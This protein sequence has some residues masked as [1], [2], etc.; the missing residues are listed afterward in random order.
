M[1]QSYRS[2]DLLAALRELDANHLAQAEPSLELL[3]AYAAHQL[4]PAQTHMLDQLLKLRPDLRLEVEALQ[5]PPPLS[6]AAE[7]ALPTG[8]PMAA[9]LPRRPGKAFSRRLFYLGTALSLLLV[10]LFFWRSTEVESPESEVVAVAQTLTLGEGVRGSGDDIPTYKAGQVLPLRLTAPAGNTYAMVFGVLGQEVSA[11]LSQTITAGKPTDLPLIAPK[12]PGRRFLIV[13]YSAEAQPI[14]P[15]LTALKT[16]SARE[17]P[18]AEVSE[19]ERKARVQR[20]LQSVV[21][22]TMS[23]ELSQLHQTRVQE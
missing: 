19:A 6:R 23:F 7:R 20:A 10:G 18:L 5:S 1:A 21:R 15:L 17:T 3:E 11:V 14:E 4:A 12:D 8:R 16:E 9:T 2:Q 22:G 13:L